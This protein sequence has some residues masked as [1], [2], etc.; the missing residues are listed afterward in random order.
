MMTTKKG[1]SFLDERNGTFPTNKNDC[2]IS[3]CNYP[4]AVETER[5]QGPSTHHFV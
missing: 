4:K 2:I 1:A 3:K 5:I